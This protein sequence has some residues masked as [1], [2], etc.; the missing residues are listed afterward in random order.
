VIK[1]IR[2]IR[3]FAI[4]FKTHAILTLSHIFVRI[5]VG[6]IKLLGLLVLVALVGS[7]EVLALLGLFELKG[8]FGLFELFGLLGLL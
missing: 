3:F 7:L 1:V 6:F 8:F 5:V 2:V 4:K